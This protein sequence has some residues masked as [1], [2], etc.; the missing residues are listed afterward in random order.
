MEIEFQVF[1]SR[2]LIFSKFFKNRNFK[3]WQSRILHFHLNLNKNFAFLGCIY[4]FSRISLSTRKNCSPI[5]SST[6]DK[7]R[8]IKILRGLH[9]NNSRTLY[10]AG[11]SAGLVTIM[12]LE[13]VLVFFREIV[14]NVGCRFFGVRQHLI[15]DLVK[16]V[17]G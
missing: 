6:W 14:D 12:L 2:F 7:L 11:D 10:I 17:H 1:M 5:F 13:D 15:E 9:A 3:F 4:N 8:H 16:S